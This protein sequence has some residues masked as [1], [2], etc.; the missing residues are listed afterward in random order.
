MSFEDRKE[1]LYNR[2]GIEDNISES[3]ALKFFRN[4][5]K[6]YLANIDS[7]IDE[8]DAIRFCSLFGYEVK[9]SYNNSMRQ[10]YGL[11][12]FECIALE[13]DWIKY[14]HKL[15][16]LFYL[17]IRSNASYQSYNNELFHKIK[18]LMNN[19][20]LSIDIMR[21]MLESGVWKNK[22]GGVFC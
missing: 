17:R 16:E 9:W 8:A 15:Q 3:A 19:S 1:K 6:N 21:A 2:F 5:I 10:R 7:R 11:N 20:K 12:I 13:S 22:L 14:L 4:G 18:E